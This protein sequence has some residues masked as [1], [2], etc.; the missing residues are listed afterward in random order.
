MSNMQAACGDRIP[1]GMLARHNDATTTCLLQHLRPISNVAAASMVTAQMHGTVALPA[2]QP[3]QACS[4]EKQ[5]SI[6]MHDICL[7]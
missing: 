5:G 6:P 3:A 7:F 1:A 4:K 2:A